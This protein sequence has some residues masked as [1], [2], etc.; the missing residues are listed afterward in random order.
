MAHEFNQFL[1]RIS[2]GVWVFVLCFLFQFITLNRLADSS[3]FNPHKDD[4]G[5]YNDWAQR[6]LTGNLTETEKTKAFYGLPGYAYIL[7]GIYSVTGGYSDGYSNFLIGQIQALLQAFTA[8]LLYL[9]AR[10]VFAESTGSIG[11]QKADWIGITA[12]L[13]W[14]LC[15]SAQVFSSIL[16]P[17]SWLICSFWFLLWWIV[18][19]DQEKKTSWW[20]PWFFQGLLIG[21]TAMA[22]ATVFILIPLLLFCL[23]RKMRFS[24]GRIASRFSRFALAAVMLFSG[25]YLGCAPI[26][27]HNRFVAKDKVFL[28]AH[29]GLNFYLG[30]HKGANGYPHIPDG[31]RASQGGLLQ[32]SLSIPERELKRPLQ[33]SEVSNYWKHKGV[34]YIK[35]N[36]FDWLRLLGVKFEN[37]WNAFQYDDVCI[38]KLMKDEGVL[39]PGL[40]FGFI[41]AIGLP[42]ILICALRFRRSLWV[43]SAVILHMLSL[44]PVFVTE[45]YR[46]AALPGLCILGVGGLWIL[47]EKLTSK[48]WRAAAFQI[49]LTVS[50]AWFVSTPQKDISFWSLEYYTAGIRAISAAETAIASKKEALGTHHLENARRNLETAYAYVPEGPDILFAMG[51]IFMVQNDH[52]TA[53]LL[54]KKSV[55]ASR[56]SANLH[57]GALNNLGVIAFLGKNWKQAEAYFQQSLNSEPNSAKTLYLLAQAAFEAGHMQVA[58]QAIAKAIAI[59]PNQPVFTEFQKKLTSH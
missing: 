28:T 49:L 39:F 2:P 15:T 42:G 34:T 40:R 59:N 50:C 12:A 55:Y 5:F 13:T 46:L 19:T 22:I 9:I 53:E 44:M 51:N 47:G 27:I 57:E 3:H 7:A 31:L 1:K 17:T 24:N 36:F 54:Y 30:N 4:M 14:S 58:K 20:N 26:W 38:I 43:S 33:R 32:D 56:N 23:Q 45:R 10:R 16:M 48:K 29:D 37:F 11:L 52:R 35:Q 25:I 6:I 18:K 8:T 21:I 41:A